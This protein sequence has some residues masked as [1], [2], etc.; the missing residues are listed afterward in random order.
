MN[1]KLP[2]HVLQAVGLEAKMVDKNSDLAIFDKTK[3]Q[4]YFIRRKKSEQM[5]ELDHVY[6]ISDEWVLHKPTGLRMVEAMEIMDKQG[7]N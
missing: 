6:G 5:R 3:F 7:E 1:K 4:R 2:M